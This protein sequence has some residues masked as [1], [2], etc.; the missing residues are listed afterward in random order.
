MVLLPLE[1]GVLG[2]VIVEFL[3]HT[4]WNNHGFLLG[5]LHTEVHIINNAFK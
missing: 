4:R 5:Q 3:F 2:E 1:N